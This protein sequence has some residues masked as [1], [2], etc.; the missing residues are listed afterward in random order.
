MSNVKKISIAAAILC[1]AS[2]TGVL[3]QTVEYNPSWYVA[4]SINLIDPDSG[5]GIDDRGEGL[6]L[7]FGK[8]ISESWDVQTGA[9]YSRS[10][11][12]GVHYQ[13]N[14]LGAD[15]LYMFSRKSFRPFVLM[16]AGYQ[17]D[18][19][20]ALAGQTSGYAPYVNA[21]VGFQLSLNDQ[22][23]M[24]ADVRRV[25]GYLRDTDFTI[26]RN[27]NN[28]LT[29]GFSYAFD[30]PRAPAVAAAPMPDPA[31]VAV[32]VTPPAPAPTPIQTPRFEKISLSSTELF[33]FDKSDL[34]MPQPKLDEIA[35]ALNNNRQVDHVVITG[36]TDRIG[37]DKYNQKLSERRAIAVKDYLVSKGIDAGRL[38]A[39][40]K[41][42]ADP[43]VICTQTKRQALIDC[44]EP[45][46]RVD[47]AQI[48]IEQLV[49]Q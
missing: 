9:T 38:N 13:Q 1:C 11:E 3:A 2:A 47:V 24:Q 5:F 20:S 48:T 32:V 31:P 4:P 19:L 45:N 22:W 34:H 29:I 10:R 27:S 43:V 7:R 17:E 26:D 33:F 35:N 15:A 41:G 28:Y 42:K 46:R 18:R 39:V 49:K 25:H 40:G 37:S 44:L 21:G 36:Y 6:G 23:S 14:L 30:K 12:N 8:P 16:G